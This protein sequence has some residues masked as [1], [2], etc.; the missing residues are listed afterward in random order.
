MTEKE[1]K[2]RQDMKELNKW[3]K[4]NP[5]ES[6]IGY[7]LV[8]L[9]LPVVILLAL[10]ALPFLLPVLAIAAICGI[11]LSFLPFPPI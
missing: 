8:V 4:E 5:N 3:A 11:S 9:G 2:H 1:R 10:F 7:L 6:Q